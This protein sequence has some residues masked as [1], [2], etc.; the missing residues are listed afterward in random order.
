MLLIFKYGIGLIFT[1]TLFSV[2][3]IQYRNLTNCYSIEIFSEMN[4]SVLTEMVFL[5]SSKCC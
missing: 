1:W 2:H 3:N 5:F 4:I